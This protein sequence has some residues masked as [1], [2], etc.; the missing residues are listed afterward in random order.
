MWVW[1]DR[2]GIVLF[3]A[4]LST[5]VFLTLI[6]LA[7]L[8]CR[9]PARRILLARVAL[10]SSLAILPLVGLGRLPRLDVIDTFVESRFFPKALFLAPSPE[11]LSDVEDA[12]MSA[13][14]RMPGRLVPVWLTDVE[15]TAAPWLPRGLTFLDLAG[16]AAGSAWLLLGVGGVYWLIGR[17]RPASPAT[18]ALFHHLIAGRANS[19][20]RAGLRVCSRLQH[21][22]VTGLLRPTILIPEALDGADTDPEPL[23]LSLL[24]EI[25]HAEHSDHWFSTIASMAQSVWFFL[26]HVWWLRS[27]L[28]IDQEFLADRSAAARYGTSSAYALSLLSLATPVAPI[29][30]VTPGRPTGGESLGGTIGVQSPLFQRIL[31]LLHC[32]YPLESRTP[33]LWSWT[34]R[35]AVIAASVAAACLV[36]RWPQPSFAL[37]SSPI[38]A[39]AGRRFQVTHFV[40]EPLH[41]AGSSERSLVFVMPMALPPVFDLDVDVR[42]T[43]PDLAQ[44]RIAGR[45][46]GNPAAPANPGASAGPAVP[47]AVAGAMAWRHVHL[48]RDHHRLTVVVDGRTVPDAEYG[49]ASS[50][51]LTIEPPSHAAAEFRHLVVTW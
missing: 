10:V 38:P 39:G 7:M 9:Q 13:V 11:E 33:R 35:L 18:R 23:R 17:S 49:D 27:R 36:I 45:P 2:I 42:A 50:D 14:G 43:L 25:A 48:H 32:P 3:D 29:T 24:H 26:P 5:A 20:S 51:W 16:V 22:V 8:A 4:T 40:A 41:D 30:G 21:P 31:M 12:A 28:L 46:L 34:S 19:A 1:M 47:M 37:P 44:I 6:I 15:S